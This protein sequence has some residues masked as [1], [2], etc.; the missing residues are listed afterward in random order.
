MIEFI[1]VVVFIGFI[2]FVVFVVFISQIPQSLPHF[3]PLNSEG[4][5][6]LPAIASLRSLRRGGRAYLTGT[7]ILS[8][9]SPDGYLLTPDR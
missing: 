1:G 3:A 2:G 6:S 7:T 9:S 8:L 4:Q 5:R